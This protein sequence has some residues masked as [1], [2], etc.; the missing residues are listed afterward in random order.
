M[1]IAIAVGAMLLGGV[2][3][4]TTP[5]DEE[6]SLQQQQQQY[7]ESQGTP[8]TQQRRPAMGSPEGG[9]MR[10]RQ[11]FGGFNGQQQQPRMQRQ[12]AVMP[13]APTEAGGMSADGGFG[14]PMAPTSGSPLMDGSRSGGSDRRSGSRSVMAPT[15][16]RSLS[17]QMGSQMGSGFRPTSSG[18]TDQTRRM[19]LQNNPAV[20]APPLSEKAFSGYKATSGVSPYMNLFRRD[21]LGT[22]D[23]YTSL[24]RPELEQRNV[25]QQYGRDIRGLERDTRMQGSS[26]QQLNKETR[27]LQ[28][29]GTPQ[30]YQNYGNYYQGYGQ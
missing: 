22:I 6:E 12:N 28:G 26:L 20:M 7:G 17:S 10:G 15:D 25:N 8:S 1:H 23:N 27:T 24:V 16:R 13:M 21:S 5:D 30:F 29:V 19:T 9:A 14:Q 11:G 3:L 18:A 4:N 2:V